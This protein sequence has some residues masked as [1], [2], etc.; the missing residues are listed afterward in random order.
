MAMLKELYYHISANLEPILKNMK[1]QTV[2]KISLRYPTS[3]KILTIGTVSQFKHKY[4]MIRDLR[5]N[6]FFN[7]IFYVIRLPLEYKLIVDNF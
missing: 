2:S 4:H 6:S 1:K 5:L 7:D 3:F